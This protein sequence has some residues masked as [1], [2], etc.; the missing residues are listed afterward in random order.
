M[1]GIRSRG[2]VKIIP[3]R[4]D[5]GEDENEW[6]RT[7][8]LAL[9]RACEIWVRIYSDIENN[10]YKV[11]DAPAGRFADPQWPEL[12][13]AKIFRLSFRDRGKLIDSVEHP[14]FAKW[15]ARDRD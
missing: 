9:L 2:S 11:F 15:A 3:V 1:V 7:K 6:N 13:H 5:D 4:L 8:H 12:K 10:A 14:L